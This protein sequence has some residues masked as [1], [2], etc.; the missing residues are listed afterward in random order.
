MDDY[1][2]PGLAALDSPYG[3]RQ[4]PMARP[5]PLAPVRLPPALIPVMELA[6]RMQSAS[7]DA[8]GRVRGA[9]PSAM[10]GN[11][12]PFRGAAPAQTDKQS[13]NSGVA[14]DF[15]TVGKNVTLDQFTNMQRKAESSGNYQALNR[16]KPGNTAS[17]AYQYT[18]RTWNNY[19]GYAKAM[20]APKAVQDRRFQEDLHN[21][22]A[23]Y[24]GDVF[25]AAADHYLPIQAGNPALWDQPA[26]LRV[27][28]KTVTVKSVASYLKSVFK[29]TPYAD[30][31]DEYINAHK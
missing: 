22:V 28:K 2:L 27:G 9:M 6:Q 11:V 18:D 1:G 3:L 25:K 29:G 5:Q 16:E 15:P 8:L 10:G 31:L 26:V 24:G 12:T 13:P 20:F 4:Q 19:G 7:S 14:G 17:G 21:R 30:Q 23:K